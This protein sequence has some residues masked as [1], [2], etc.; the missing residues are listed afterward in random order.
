MIVVAVLVIAVYSYVGIPTI[1]E[2]FR[3]SEDQIETK[4]GTSTIDKISSGRVSV[5]Q[6]GWELFKESPLI[7]NGFGATLYFTNGP[8]I[9][10][11]WLKRLVD[12]GIIFVLPLIFLFVSLYKTII[13][14]TRRYY[15][16]ENHKILIRT[17]FISSIFISMLEPNYLIGSFQGEAFFWALISTYLK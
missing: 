10:N 2:Y 7:G 9:H 14:K 5:Y 17:L 11:T 4:E 16:G 3:A 1:E 15:N 12:G 6:L 8:D 13:K